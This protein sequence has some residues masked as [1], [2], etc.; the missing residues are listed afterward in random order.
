M[1]EPPDRQ[2]LRRLPRRRAGRHAARGAGTGCRRHGATT[3][4]RS[5]GCTS[6]PRPAGAGWPGGCSPTS[7]RPRGR[8]RR[9]DGAGDRQAARGDRALLVLGLRRRSRASAIYRD[10]PSRGASA[11][12]WTRS[13]PPAEATCPSR[14]RCDVA[15]VGRTLLARLGPSGPDPF[16]ELAT[17]TY[18]SSSI[19][20]PSSAPR[21]AGCS[22]ARAG[23]PPRPARPSRRRSARPRWTSCPRPAPAGRRARAGRARS[24]ARPPGRASPRARGGSAPRRTPPASSGGAAASATTNGLVAAAR[25]W[26]PPGGP[27]PARSRRRRRRAPA[28]ASSSDRVPV[29]QPRSATRAGAGGSRASSSSRQAARTAGSRSPW[30]AASSNVAA[31]ASHRSMPARVMG[32]T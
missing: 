28:S 20:A 21:A 31:S 25:P 8:R 32:Q 24:A 10:A 18:R 11:S 1:F 6:R 9:G 5:S 16:R 17:T 23:R 15:S 26:R 2:L 30:S 14:G 22:V 4:P 3:A 13:R 27:S 29:P 7:R 12:C 19:S